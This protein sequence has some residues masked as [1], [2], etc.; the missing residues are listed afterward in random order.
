MSISQAEELFI[1]I[2][3]CILLL[4]HLHSR[5]IQ[6][7][8]IKK[9]PDT[10]PFSKIRHPTFPAV[11]RFNSLQNSLHFITL[12]TFHYIPLHSITNSL[13]THY[14]LITNSLQTH[15]RLNTFHY[16]HYKSNTLHTSINSS[17]TR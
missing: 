7:V 15:Y 3:V 4:Q 10:K 16:I 9:I 13:Q 5:K 8:P 12:I 11:E 2:L 1:I 6:D 14:K 17:V